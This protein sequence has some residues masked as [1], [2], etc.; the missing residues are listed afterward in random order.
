MLSVIMV[1]SGIPEWDDFTV[2]AI[3]SMKFQSPGA[4]DNIEFIVTDNG[5]EGR[6]DI[7]TDTML[8]YSVMV[9]KCARRATGNRLL[10]LN[11]DI[12]ARGDWYKCVM[13]HS[14]YPYCG[15]V[16]LTKEGVTY[17][18][19]WCISIERDLWHLLN[20]MNEKYKNSWDDVDLAWRLRRLGIPAA[21]MPMPMSHIWGATRHRYKGSNA[22]DEES[23]Q[24]MLAR[25]RETKYGWSRHEISS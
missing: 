24:Y 4:W 20:G 12:T 10:I 21:H 1:S 15:P 11:N 22:W 8:P 17:V 5:G 25:I 7:N 2:P 9:N 14:G 3:K 19:G 13:E 6:G 16:L 18:E 23:R